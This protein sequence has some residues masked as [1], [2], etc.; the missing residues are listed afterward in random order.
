MKRNNKQIDRENFYFFENVKL[1][2]LRS[3]N[4]SFDPL[5]VFARIIHVVSLSVYTTV[6]PTQICLV[7]YWSALTMCINLNIA[8]SFQGPKEFT[9]K[10]RNYFFSGHTQQYKTSK[11]DWL[12]ARNICREYCMDLVSIETQEENNLIFRLIQQSESFFEIIS[13]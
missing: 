11:V 3:N 7:K 6:N 5:F 13:R 4:R 9:Y 8:F 12:E 2:F 10:G 1:Y